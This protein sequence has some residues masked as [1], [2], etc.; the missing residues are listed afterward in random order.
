MYEEGDEGD[1]EFTN[2]NGFVKKTVLNKIYI[3]YKLT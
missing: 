3:I 1:N 2:D